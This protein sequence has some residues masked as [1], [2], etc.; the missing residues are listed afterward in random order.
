MGLSTKLKVK[1]EGG[2]NGS[3]SVEVSNERNKRIVS[4]SG[5]ASLKEMFRVSYFY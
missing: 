5:R 1:T 2:L 4:R 3:P